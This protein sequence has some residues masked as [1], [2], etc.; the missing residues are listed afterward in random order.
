MYIIRQIST[1]WYGQKIV[2]IKPKRAAAAVREMR[3]TNEFL[4]LEK[5]FGLEPAVAF[6][7]AV[8]SRI[9]AAIRR[10][11]HAPER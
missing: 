2:I 8:A 5:G 4:A 10:T 6:E 11:R 1:V 3:K 7:I 9:T